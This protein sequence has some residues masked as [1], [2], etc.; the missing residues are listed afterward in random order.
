M[1]TIIQILF[2]KG[3]FD[4]Y[5]NADEVL[6]DYLL[7]EDEKRCTPDLEEVNDVI[8]WFCS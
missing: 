7:I 8:Q 6:K 3:L 1:K 4:N 2:D 5:D